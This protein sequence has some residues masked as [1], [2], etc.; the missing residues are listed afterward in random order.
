MA[1]GDGGTGQS[2]APALWMALI[3][4]SHQNLPGER[5]ADTQAHLSYLT[6]EVM[7]L[8]LPVPWVLCCWK[9]WVPACLS[10]LASACMILGLPFTLRAEKLPC[11]LRLFSRNVPCYVKAR[12]PFLPQN[13]GG[14]LYEEVVTAVSFL[15]ASQVFFVLGLVKSDLLWKHLCCR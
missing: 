8:E 11:S 14:L 6:E 9:R 1:C 2:N 15:L 3:A 10:A 12:G 7:S 5:H 13:E 4:G